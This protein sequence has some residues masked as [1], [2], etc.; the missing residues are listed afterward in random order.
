MQPGGG[1]QPPASGPSSPA[2]I[3]IEGPGGFLAGA[4]RTQNAPWKALQTL[5]V[6]CAHSVRSSSHDPNTENQPGHVQ[7][8]WQPAAASGTSPEGRSDLELGQE[9][10]LAEPPTATNR[11]KSSGTSSEP[12]TQAVQLEAER[13]AA[14]FVSTD[15]SNEVVLRFDFMTSKD[16]RVRSDTPLTTPYG[17]C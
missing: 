15:A 6:E 2:A 11:F 16:T 12:N 3:D 9:S 5:A 10:P 8:Q 7:Q 14:K 13:V 4:P 1:P 17:P